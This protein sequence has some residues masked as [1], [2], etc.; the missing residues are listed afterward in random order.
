ML[1]VEKSDGM[2]STCTV[3]VAISFGISAVGD[4]DG[5]T[6][7]TRVKVSAGGVTVTATRFQMAVIE[8]SGGSN[9]QTQRIDSVADFATT[10]TSYV[11]VTNITLTIGNFSG[12]KYIAMGTAT[13][14][15]SAG[16]GFTHTQLVHGST[17]FI[18]ATTANPGPNAADEN[19][20]HTVVLEDTDGS[21]LKMQARVTSGTGTLRDTA[22]A[23][24]YITTLEFKMSNTITT[25]QDVL[26]SD[27]TTTSTSYVDITGLTVTLNASGKFYT[28]SSLP[29]SNNFD[30]GF[31]STNIRFGAVDTKDF[32]Y[33]NEGTSERP[34]TA[35]ACHAGDSGSEVLKL[36]GKVETGGTSKWHGDTVQ[37]CRYAV[38]QID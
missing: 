18:G 8:I 29:C 7:K 19:T 16:A 32:A 23:G 26:A 21:T 17:E 30:G 1:V 27:F 10:S 33:R 20:Q 38:L 2:S 37:A 14:E 6:V 13:P 15:N 3:T 9:L 34:R 36:Q 11:D 31:A 35:N 5:R 25:E 12:G 4:L 28:I 22:D 24:H